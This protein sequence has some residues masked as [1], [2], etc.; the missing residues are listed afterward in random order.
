MILN[1]QTF[2]KVNSD[3]SAMNSKLQIVRIIGINFYLT[4]IK[5]YESKNNCQ[6]IQMIHNKL[7]S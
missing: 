6:T 2:L 7:L 4:F 3:Y 5:M 1:C